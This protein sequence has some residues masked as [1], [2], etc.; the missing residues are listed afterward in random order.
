MF[1]HIDGICVFKLHSI[2][3]P[4]DDELLNKN[5]KNF[6]NNNICRKIVKNI[7]L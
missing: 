7:N 3:F 5:A 1:F 4:D 6:Y 2:S